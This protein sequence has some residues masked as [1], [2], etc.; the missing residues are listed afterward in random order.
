MYEPGRPYCCS[1]NGSAECV[2]TCLVRLPE[3]KEVLLH[4]SQTYGSSPKCKRMCL[5]RS[6]E[7][8]DD[9][10]HASQ[11]YGL[12]PECIRMCVARLED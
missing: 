4:V 6:L 11:T 8:E 1:A 2:H 5:A 3:W 7:L 10:P 9:L 12:S